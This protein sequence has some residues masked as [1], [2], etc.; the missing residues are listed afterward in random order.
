MLAHEIGK[1]FRWLEIVSTN[2][3]KA[4]RNPTNDIVLKNL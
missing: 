2:A 4:Q 3:K 1:V